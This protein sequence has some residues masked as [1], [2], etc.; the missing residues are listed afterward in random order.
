MIP[1]PRVRYRAQL[2]RLL[3]PRL[4]GVREVTADGLREIS[5]VD[6]SAIDP[7]LLQMAR[8]ERAANTSL[9]KYSDWIHNIAVFRVVDGAGGVDYL[10]AG[11]TPKG[12]DPIS[13]VNRPV[14]IHSEAHI[15]GQLELVRDLAAGSR[16]DQLYSERIPC[17][18]CSDYLKLSE[19]C[20]GALVFFSVPDR[21]GP[22]SKTAM[23]RMQYG[24]PAKVSG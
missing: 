12:R 17:S 3:G 18:S 11:N 10:S 13:K 6:P 15:L 23:L 4:V 5:G 24:L 22:Q 14:G 20:R 19:P 9:D 1:D 7:M 16:V 2:N 21:C 8:E